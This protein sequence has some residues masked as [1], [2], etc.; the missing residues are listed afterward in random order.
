MYKVLIVDDERLIR[1]GLRTLIDWEDY[2]FIVA[3]TAADGRDALDKLARLDPDL[4]IADIRMPGMSGLELME[5]LRNGRPRL[6]RFVF[7]SGY[8]DFDYAREAL[9][10]KA[11]GYMLK[12]VDEDELADY[13]VKVRHSLDEERR[14]GAAD[15][16]M[17]AHPLQQVW[18]DVSVP[19][20]D[21]GGR[22]GHGRAE[23]PEPLD[24]AE[25]EEK[26]LLAL[27]IGDAEAAG[28]QIRGLGEAMLTAKVSEQ[29]VKAAFARILTETLAGLSRHHPEIRAREEALTTELFESVNEDRY[30]GMLRRLVRLAEEI[31]A[32]MQ[33]YGSDRQVR[34]MIDLI[35]RNYARQ[36]KLETLAELL[37]YNSSYLGKLFKASTGEHFNTYLDKVRIE[38][39]KEL[40]AQGM[41]VYQVAEQVGYANV[42]YF[43]G[44]FR[45]YVGESPSAYRKKE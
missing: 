18:F 41:K 23:T 40:L 12:P 30:S 24:W 34:K 35:H 20:A 8:A 38:K 7:L 5:Q 36:L 32:G 6:P 1:D 14:G 13:L 43:H 16:G 39:A 19:S 9:R 21:E 45:K 26:L 4:V 22:N 15:P 29:S 25:A 37:N 3:D 27:D 42:D 28:A 17:A 31:A 10:M 11:E 2:G 44:K 33:P